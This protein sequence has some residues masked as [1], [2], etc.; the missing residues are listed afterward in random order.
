MNK[1]NKIVK[2]FI[3][4]VGGKTQIIDKVISKFPH[5][6]QNYHEL[7]LGG[8]SV[9]LAVLSSNHIKITGTINVYDNNIILINVYKNIQN[10]HLELLNVT[11]TIIKEYI[12]CKGTEINRKPKNLTEAKTSKESYYYWLRKEFNKQNDKSSLYTSSLFIILNKLCFRGLYREGPNGFNVPFGHYKTVPEIIN[13]NH[14][15]IIHNLIKSV[16][17]LHLDFEESFKLIKN[18]DFVYMDPPCAPETST[19]F[20][21]YTKIGFNENKHKKLF[22]LTNELNEKNVKFVMSNSNV[23]MVKNNLIDY[24]IEEIL[25]KRSINSKTPDSKTLEI[26]IFN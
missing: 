6:I 25:C 22:E 8:G 3:K 20:V 17:F 13:E 24:N 18:N 26:F 2:P 1:E 23:D 7:F 14:I 10:N 16:N 9:L 15:T 11:K 4:W 19:S 5:N 21:A 12:K